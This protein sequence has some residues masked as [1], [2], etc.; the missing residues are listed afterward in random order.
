[1]TSKELAQRLLCNVGRQIGDEKIG[2][3]GKH[4]IRDIEGQAFACCLP[5]GLLD[6]YFR[7]GPRKL[8][9]TD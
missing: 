7:S 1:M 9:G 4:R 5:Q 3:L 6:P 2:R 8:E